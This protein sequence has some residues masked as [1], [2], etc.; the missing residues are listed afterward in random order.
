MSANLALIY[1]YNNQTN[2]L[3]EGIACTF[4]QNIYKG[5]FAPAF[6]NGVLIRAVYSLKAARVSLSLA[7]LMLTSGLNLASSTT[8]DLIITL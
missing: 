2:Q 3:Y 1:L 8:S 4:V 7:K 5:A 6:V